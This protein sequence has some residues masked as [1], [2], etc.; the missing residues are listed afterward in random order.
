MPPMR[1]PATLLRAMMSCGATGGQTIRCRY[2]IFSQVDEHCD[3][4][5][6]AHHQ[7]AA[8]QHLRTPSPQ[9]KDPPPHPPYREGVDGEG[10]L[11]RAHHAEGAVDGESAEVEVGVV[12]A[13]HRI[14][15]EIALARH[16]GHLILVRRAH[17]LGAQLL[18]RRL[19]AHAGGEDVDGVAHGESELDGHVA[20]PSEADDARRAR[21]AFGLS[22]EVGERR[23]GRDACA[24]QGS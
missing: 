10:G 24:Q 13:A 2:E 5:A 19:L 18:H 22:A 1:E 21:R 6:S 8:G 20:Q 9:P 15:D 12:V 4:Q 3:E 7:K 14:E 17:E 16:G 23:V 11:R